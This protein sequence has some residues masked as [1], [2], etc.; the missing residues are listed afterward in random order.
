M[1][2]N[3]LSREGGGGISQLVGCLV[4]HSLRCLFHATHRSASSPRLC[5]WTSHG[6]A[7]ALDA[8]GKAGKLFAT[9][10]KGKGNPVDHV[11][12]T[13]L[14]NPPLAPW[15]RADGADATLRKATEKASHENGFIYHQKMPAEL[16][17]APEPKGLVLVGAI[18]ALYRNWLFGFCHCLYCSLFYLPRRRLHLPLAEG[19]RDRCCRRRP[20]RCRRPRLTGPRSASP[21]KR[22]PCAARYVR[23][24]SRERE[25]IRERYCVKEVIELGWAM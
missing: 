23:A 15:C 5:V 4:R 19:V 10:A 18:W 20:S 6:C 21:W 3:A 24:E 16:S 9:A 11:V 17:A 14:G 22:F 1:G 2:E 13:T 7:A 25:I 12:F 8:A